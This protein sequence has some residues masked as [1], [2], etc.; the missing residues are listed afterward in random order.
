MTIDTFF[1]KEKQ[2][3]NLN[4]NFYILQLICLLVEFGNEGR[5]FFF[6]SGKFYSFEIAFFYC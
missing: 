3:E 6:Q 2:T 1:V 5:E 4:L